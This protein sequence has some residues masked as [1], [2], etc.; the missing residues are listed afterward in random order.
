MNV[1]VMITAK[2]C[3][4]KFHTAS[5]V[6][7]GAPNKAA[8]QTAL[9]LTFNDKKMIAIKA[10]SCVAINCQAAEIA[11]KRLSSSYNYPEFTLD[12]LSSLPAATP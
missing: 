1:V 2:R 6:P 11:P 8:M 3:P 9:K 10:A 5:A 4:G 7:I 12:E